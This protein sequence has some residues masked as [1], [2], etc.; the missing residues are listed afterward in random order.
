MYKS[1]LQ[2]SKKMF[3]YNCYLVWS[4][5]SNSACW[6]A[7]TMMFLDDRCDVGPSDIYGTYVVHS[8]SDMRSTVFVLY[9]I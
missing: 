9:D 7:F 3:N 2:D 6:C 4:I 1:T 8:Q 5:C